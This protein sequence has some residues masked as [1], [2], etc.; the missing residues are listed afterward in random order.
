MILSLIG[1][2]FTPEEFSNSDHQ[3][4]GRFDEYG[5][6]QGTVWIYGDAIDNHVISWKGATGRQT[7][8]GPFEIS[9]AANEGKNRYSMLPPEEHV[10]MSRKMEMIGGLYIYCDGIRI[11]PYGNTDYDWLEIELRRTKSFSYYYFSHR[12]MF[13]VVKINKNKNSRLTEKA[14]REGFREN[15]AYR[16]FKSILKNFLVQMAADFFPPCGFA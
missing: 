7:L 2:F 6:F 9:V 14:G 10:R 12:K 5:Q 11:L 15:K 13:G 8:C 4:R 16:Q 3:I 1:E